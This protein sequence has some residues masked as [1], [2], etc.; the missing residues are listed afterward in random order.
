MWII[1]RSRDDQI[2]NKIINHFSTPRER[3]GGSQYR[4]RGK[5]RVNG[6]IVVAMV[7]L[8]FP[9]YVLSGTVSLWVEWSSIDGLVENYRLIRW[10]PKKYNNVGTVSKY[11]RKIVEKRGKMDIANTHIDRWQL[12]GTDTSIKNGGLTSSFLK[13]LNTLYILLCETCLSRT[14]NKE[15]PCGKHGNQYS[16]EFS[17]GAHLWLAW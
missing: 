6:L 14:L 3:V 12:P 15:E 4:T 10:K 8:S 11:N 16:I 13:S 2:Y 5:L 9:N 17:N 7:I 1:C